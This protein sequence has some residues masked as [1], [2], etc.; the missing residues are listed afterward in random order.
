MILGIAVGKIEKIEPQPD[1]VKISFWY[2]DQQKVPA[3]AKAVIVSPSLV[4]VR[5]MQFTPAYTG[6]AAMATTQ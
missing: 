5:S 6:G 4:T 2:D 3:D 1:G